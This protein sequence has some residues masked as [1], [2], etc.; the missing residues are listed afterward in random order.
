[1][2]LF[3]KINDFAKTA[4]EKT[5]NAIE[6]TRL[7]AKVDSE[8]RSLTAIIK[9]IGEYYVAK[10][11][12]GEKLED[13]VMSIYEGVLQS[14]KTI[15]ELKSEIEVLKGPKPEEKG[16]VKYCPS[17]GKELD[18]DAKFCLNCGRQQ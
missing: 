12:S 1:M 17:C 16:P 8:D 4:T 14:R 3:D 13:E 15:N 6:I 7:S 11:D 10:M 5:N 9:K 18:M 2:A